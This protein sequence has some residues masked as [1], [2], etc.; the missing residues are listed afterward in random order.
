MILKVCKTIS[1]QG[2]VNSAVEKYVKHQ[3][4]EKQEGCLTKE[5]SFAV[6]LS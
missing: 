1:T 4:E 6:Y 3:V 2:S 5:A